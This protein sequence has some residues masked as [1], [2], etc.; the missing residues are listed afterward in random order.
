MTAENRLWGQ[1]RIQ[2]ELARLGFTVSARTVAKY[3]N[4]RHSR[5][6]SS[7][8]RKFL[9]RHESSIWACDFFCVKTVLFQTLYVFFVIRH[10]NRE[11]LH[12]AVTP[13]PTA[14]WLAQ[15]IV[16]CCAWDRLPPR[17]LIHDRD[18]RYG[19]TFDR[20]L[21]G[22]GTKQVRTPFRAPR[23]NAISERWVKSVRTECLDH[24]L[25]FNEAHLRRA[26]AGYAAYFNYWR[27]HGSLGQRASPR[28]H[29][30][31]VST[32]RGQLQD[33]GRARPGW[34][35]SHLACIFAPFTLTFH[36]G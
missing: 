27:P 22:L 20:R 36:D 23:A 29:C 31:S 24:L 33:H 32:S 35:A 17:S 25:V 19:A 15:Q 12:V 34:I 13:F 6:P 2:A 1:K 11:I 3:M 9:K 10:V 28:L 21:R 5:G 8:W 7:G 4:S 18:S 14:E 26:I 16:E 30:A